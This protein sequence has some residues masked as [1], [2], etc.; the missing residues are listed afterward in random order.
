MEHCDFVVVGAGIMG[1]FI[2]YFL[3]E[4]RKKLKMTHK[5]KIKWFEQYEIN[6]D[7]G[8][9]HGDS[10]IMRTGDPDMLKAK[11]S[12]LSYNLF[13]TLDKKSNTKLMHNI[14]YLSFGDKNNNLVLKEYENNK[15]LNV[16][17]KR[18]EN[19]NAIHINHKTEVGFLQSAG[20][21]ILL[22]DKILK[23]LHQ[24]IKHQYGVTLNENCK[25]LNINKNNSTITY[26]CTNNN[27][28]NTKYIKYSQKVIL[29]TGAY[30]NIILSNSDL[31]IIP[32]TISNE[33]CCYFKPKKGFESHFDININN[34][35]SV[36]MP[37]FIRYPD[38]NINSQNDKNIN[39]LLNKYYFYGIPSVIPSLGVKVDI[40]DV[41]KLDY[42][43]PLNLND[44]IYN[45]RSFSVNKHILKY[46]QLF[47]KQYIP[48]LDVNEY[49]VIRC[50]Y[51]IPEDN[52]FVIG[53]HYECENIFLCFGFCGC[54]F[55]LSA[56]IGL[57]IAKQMLNCD[58][59]C[60]DY[61]QYPIQYLSRFNPIR[62]RKCK[63]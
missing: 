24:S 20:T 38:A 46:S 50:L 12:K 18:Y 57:L 35:S 13:K 40:E 19:T 59:F 22:A 36:K 3:C 48:D 45:N 9:S 28:Q 47:A 27:N 58:D 43:E 26:T 17:Q 31:S 49:K 25:I 44:L 29:A 32:Y 8:S 54:G 11:M 42:G 1:S 16:K 55:K 56:L 37:V 6:T 39:Y 2:T 14:K 52:D 41:D 33:Q 63:L 21:A 4:L 7:K 53:N 60:N 30:T 5:I 23:T 51:S 62:F 15:L 10:R 61:I 34:N